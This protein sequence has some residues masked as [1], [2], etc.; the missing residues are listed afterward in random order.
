MNPRQYYVYILASASNSTIYAGITNDIVRRLYE[1]QQGSAQGFTKRYQVNKLVYFE[2]FDQPELA[3]DR[4]K[5]IKSW[6]R[7][8]KNRLI[9]SKNPYW[10]DLSN[11]VNC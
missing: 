3:I 5:Q 10:M 2:V 7:L 8:K 9:E 11:L 1:H 6:S 4:E